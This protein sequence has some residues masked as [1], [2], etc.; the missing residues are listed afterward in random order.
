M[1][2]AWSLKLSSTDKL[3]LLA[4]ADWSNDDGLCWPSM[5][6]LAEKSGLTGRAIRTSIGRLKEAGHLTRN[7]VPGKG[8]RYSVH[9]G[10]TFPPETRSARKAM[11]P[12]PVSPRNETTETPERRSANTSVTTNTS[13][14]ASPSSRARTPETGRYHRLPEGWTPTKDLPEALAAK[15]AQWPPGKMA[16][17][18][19][20]MR[21]WA[22]NAKNE[23]GKGK[24]LCWDTAWH[25]WLRRADDDWKS[26]PASRSGSRNGLFDAAVEWARGDNDPHGDGRAIA[27]R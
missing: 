1:T 4:L 11:P 13:Q 2:A 16:D 23:N 9:P 18:L 14:K 20:A 25:G 19:D 22:A 21:D 10:T 12:E 6:Q 8:V 5:A 3:V 26:K 15:L 24:K 17:E 7:E 27:H